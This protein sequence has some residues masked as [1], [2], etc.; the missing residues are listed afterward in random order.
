MPNA[1]TPFL[2]PASPFVLPGSPFDALMGAYGTELQWAK[3][4]QCPC[5]LGNSDIPGSPDP[6]CTSCGGRGVYWDAFGPS[7]QG[8]LTHIGRTN[9]GPEPGVR[10][11]TTE[12]GIW[13][14][15][16]V[17]TI[18]FSAGDVWSEASVMDAFLQV[19]A[20]QR[21]NTT[22]VVGGTAT[23]PYQQS[24][25]IAASGAV[26]VYDAQTHSVIDDVAYTASSG[27]VTLTDPSFGP[28]T[29]YTV[30]YSAAPVFIAFRQSGGAPHFRPLG[31]QGAQLPLRLHCQILD[32]W[33]RTRN[34]LSP[35]SP[36]AG[37]NGA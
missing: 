6:Q 18:P 12:G 32:L 25:S 13:T 7:F 27:V 20:V 26:R 36:Q 33:T 30:E 1:N 19:Q 17:I 8:L 22:L 16:P 21:F 11:N 23:L 10:T 5:T 4:H 31:A 29:A 9:F 14:A 2:P 15:N 37:H 35:F 3:G 34:G 24:L 28:G